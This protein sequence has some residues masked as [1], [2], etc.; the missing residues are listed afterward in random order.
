MPII[1][2]PTITMKPTPSAMRAPASDARQRGRQHDAAEECAAPATSIVRAAR[3]S[4]GSTH[5]HRGDDVGQHHP[6]AAV[7]DEEHLRR[8]A[9]A[10]PD[11]RERQ[12]A[13]A[14]RPSGRRRRPAPV[15]RS[16]SGTRRSPGRAASASA[17]ASDEAREDPLQRDRDVVQ[18]SDALRE[19][20]RRRVRRS[21]SRAAIGGGNS[22]PAQP[23]RAP[24]ADLPER[25]QDARPARADTPSRA[26]RDAARAVAGGGARR[27]CSA[28][29]IAS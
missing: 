4:T 29:Q 23:A 14:S 22:G 16:S 10:E 1:S 11:D 15:S 17:S 8:L 24:T 9:D 13:T 21:S 25:E 6:E 12:Q 3:I 20:R 27:H 7:A 2:A 26:S 5:L 18:S 19:S 28:A